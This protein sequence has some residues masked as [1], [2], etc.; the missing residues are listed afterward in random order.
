MSKQKK[1][2]KKT[3][4]EKTK[5]KKT[6]VYDSASELYNEQLGKY[7]DEYYDLSDAERRKQNTNVNLKLFLG[8]YDY[9]DQFEI[10][11]STDKEEPVDL[12]TCHH[13]KVMKK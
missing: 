2:K 13:Q 9:H 10:E 1:T 5:K 7:S 4:T 8:A 12:S 11:E 6:N 3:Q